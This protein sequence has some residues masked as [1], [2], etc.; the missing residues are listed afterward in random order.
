MQ[1]FALVLLL[2]MISGISAAAS[3]RYVSD[4]MEITMR[5]GKGTQY[6]ILRSL[7]SGLRLEVLETDKTSGYSH[8][9][10]PSGKT[11]WVLTRYLMKQPPARLQLAAMKKRLTEMQA[12]NQRL[13]A[14]LLALNEQKN[15]AEKARGKLR[16][17][18]QRLARE[19]AEIRR[20]SANAIQLAE[21]NR[22]LKERLVSTDRELQRLRQEN[23]SLN[24]RSKRDWFLVGAVVVIVSM[25]FGIMLTRIR[26]RKKTSWGDL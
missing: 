9:R 11:G 26:W 3:V 19:L 10:T 17:R 23:E 8:V 6:A 12:E 4:Q 25:L 13:R 24:D 18:S 14:Q 22:A 2:T 5:R 21:E 16:L 1:R 20:V 15:T 7:P